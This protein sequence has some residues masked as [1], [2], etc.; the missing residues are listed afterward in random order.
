MQM[1][2][3]VVVLLCYR[4]VT[5]SVIVVPATAETTAV[6]QGSEKSLEKV[7]Q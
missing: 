5:G 7:K 2:A 3:L 1:L 4:T 6:A